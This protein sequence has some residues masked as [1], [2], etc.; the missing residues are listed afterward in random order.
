[1]VSSACWLFM[2]SP[3]DSRIRRCRPALGTFVEMDVVGNE[4]DV[5]QAV[6][7]AYS[8]INQIQRLMSLHDPASE[9]NRLNH[10]AHRRAVKVHPLTW[11]VLT[12][13]C[14][15]AVVSNGAFDPTAAPTLKFRGPKVRTKSVAWQRGNWSD[16][17]FL[18]RLRIRFK[19]QLQIDL[20]GIAKGFAVDRA[21][22]TLQTRGMRSGFVSAGGDLRVFGSDYRIHLRH[23]VGPT[24]IV[25]PILLRDEAMATSANT[26]SR[27]GEMPDEIGHLIEPRT[28]VAWRG[29]SSVTVRCKS[30]LIADAL[31]K[32]VLFGGDSAEAVLSQYDSVAI[33]LEVQEP[34]LA[35]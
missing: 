12:K 7:E 17:H 5:E 15:M 2:K 4:E 34:D 18:P 29:E 35:V 6:G 19:R 31:T 11:Y 1:M 13:A 8:V 28:K 20:G 30:C 24:G 14:E 22:E 3:S 26:F 23:P 32:V 27:R 10:E 9:L 33:V 16:I 21:I 25:P